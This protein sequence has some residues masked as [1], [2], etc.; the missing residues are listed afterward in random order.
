MEKRIKLF[1]IHILLLIFFLYNWCFPFKIIILKFLKN[2]YFI[3]VDLLGINHAL[4][5]GI[6]IKG[7]NQILPF[8][9]KKC[10]FFSNNFNKYFNN[11]LKP[12]FYYKPR[13]KIEE[14]DYNQ[15]VK[16]KLINKCIL[17]PLF[18]PSHWFHFP[19]EK[20]WK[21]KYF[22]K[23]LK[24]VKGVVVHSN[25]V[26][27]HIINKTNNSIYLNKFFIMR[28]C[29][30]IKPKQVKSFENRIF[31]IIFFEKYMDLNRLKQGKELLDLLKKAK[32]KIVLMKYGSYNKTII[33]KLANNSKFIIYFS[34]YDTG[35]IGLKEIQNYGVIAFTHQKDLVI[36]NETSFYIPELAS[37]DKIKI[38]SEKILKIIDKF[39]SKNP[40]TTLIAEKNQMI[41]KCENALIDLCNN[42]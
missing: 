31:D 12:D 30:N 25:R 34:F 9:S 7:I 22:S 20:L 1:F 32:K 37:L 28:P 15:L 35:A 6:L 41:N 16:E 11:I 19:Y 23:I 27:D 5:P 21:E 8:I 42:L 39:S 18:V 38:A 2:R 26:R 3:N 13:P 40:S 33:M 14:E 17:G 29:T 36:N 4:G 24:S 10:I